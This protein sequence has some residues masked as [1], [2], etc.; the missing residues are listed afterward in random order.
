MSTYVY[1]KILESAPQRYD[2]GIRLLSGGR[3]GDLYRHVA[4]AAVAGLTSPRVLEFGCGTGNL[5]AALLERGASVVAVDWNPEM[6]AVAAE[7]LGAKDG[8]LQLQEM[9]AVEI[10]DRFPA[11]S[12][13]A[14]ASTLALSEMSEDEQL[15]VLRAAYK[16]LHPGGRLA[17]GDEVRPQHLGQRLL[18]ACTR[19]P[20]AVVTYLVTQ[21]STS[22]VTD[23]AGTIRQA[24]FSIS[25]ETRTALGSMSVVVAEKSA[26]SQPAA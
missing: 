7:K 13:D 26:A 2:L 14:V 20:V 22:A 25:S 10:A 15:Y 16:V 19:W 1:M 11:G 18:H 23:L 12:F 8:R 3:V 17:I 5:T 6:L 9:A 24:G 21:T 4:D